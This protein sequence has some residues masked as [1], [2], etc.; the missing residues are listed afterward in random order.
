MEPAFL[1][2]DE[3]LEIHRDQITR[4]GGTTG[5]RDLGLLQSA[6]AMPAAA[7]EGR[8]LHGDLFEMAA[9]YLFHITCNHPFLD[10]NKRVGT[11][12]AIVF[13]ELNGLELEAEGDSLEALVT[14]VAEGR[15]DKPQIAEFFRSNTH[16]SSPRDTSRQSPQ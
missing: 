10:G 9:A 1:T 4:Y 6:A 13:L 5:I 2:L 7:F 15:A 3:I 12:A 16:P 11:V 14:A 8:Y